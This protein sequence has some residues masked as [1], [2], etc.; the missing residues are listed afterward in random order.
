MP[1]QTFDTTTTLPTS[2]CTQSDFYQL[3]KMLQPV[4]GLVD[5]TSI[6]VDTSTHALKGGNY[7]PFF[8]KVTKTFTDL[9]QASLTFDIELFLLPPGGFLHAI[10]LKHSAAFTGGAISAYTLSIGIGANLTKYMAAKSVFSAPS[11]TSFY[12]TWGPF[13]NSVLPPAFVNIDNAI[14]GLTISAAYAQAEVQALRAACET[15]AD[16]CRA[17]R[18]ALAAYSAGT[19]GMET[20]SANTSIRLAATSVGANTNVATA[21]SVDVYVL[22]SI[23]Q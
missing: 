21:G 11:A 16:D 23:L 7:A 5:G 8:R 17:L 13:F 3:V 9:A 6:Q 14:G 20:S 18:A 22:Y 4:S 1:T 2:S 10:M 19:V 15:L 12:I